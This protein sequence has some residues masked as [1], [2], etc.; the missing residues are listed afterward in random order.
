MPNELS[1]EQRA[2]RR[3]QREV[4]RTRFVKEFPAT[5]IAEMNLARQVEEL[6]EIL[7]SFAGIDDC[8]ICEIDYLCG[9]G[10]VER[11]REVLAKTEVI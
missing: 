5:T 7:V 11:S 6:R 1:L 9:T 4:T 8:D 10:V 3:A 2:E